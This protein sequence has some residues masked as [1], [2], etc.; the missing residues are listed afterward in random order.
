VELLKSQHKLSSDT[1]RSNIMSVLR[2]TAVI[3]KGIVKWVTGISKFIPP[4]AIQIG[5]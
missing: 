2:D 4:C 1:I 3:K 5:K